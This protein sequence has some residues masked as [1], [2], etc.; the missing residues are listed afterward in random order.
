MRV[1]K[2]HICSKNI[3][4]SSTYSKIEFSLY[5]FLEMIWGQEHPFKSE[6]ASALFCVVL[7]SSL[8]STL[9]ADKKEFNAPSGR[10]TLLTLVFSKI[11]GSK[12]HSYFVLFLQVGTRLIS[13]ENSLKLYFILLSLL[14]NYH[15]LMS[16][17]T[18]MS[19][20]KFLRRTEKAFLS[21][22]VKTK[23]KRQV[24]RTFWSLALK[25]A[26]ALFA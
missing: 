16:F 24:L 2:I 22:T 3:P 14:F 12:T 19:L 18:K 15:K 13:D 1:I 20:T 5:W 23:T 10:W 11:F 26:R 7:W 4:C 25:N 8:V 6:A 21:H 9:D 17:L